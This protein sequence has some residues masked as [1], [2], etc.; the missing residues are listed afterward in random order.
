MK[1]MQLVILLLISSSVFTMDNEVSKVNY[2]LVYSS[3]KES[4]QGRFSEFVAKA[5]NEIS[6]L[7]SDYTSVIENISRMLTEHQISLKI[8]EQNSG[9]LA[10]F[11]HNLDEDTDF[12]GN[13][14]LT[15]DA[16]GKI[17]SEGLSI[18]I[19]CQYARD[20]RSFVVFNKDGTQDLLCETPYCGNEMVNDETG[21]VL[22]EI[23]VTLC[24]FYLILFHEL[25]H[26]KHFLDTV[27]FQSS[28]LEEKA[29]IPYGKA[30][31]V[32]NK[33]SY[34]SK[35]TKEQKAAFGDIAEFEDNIFVEQLYNELESVATEAD[36]TKWK[37]N[38][39][40]KEKALELKGAGLTK[41]NETEEY[42]WS[43]QKIDLSMV[44]QLAARPD[45]E[46]LEEIRTVFG[47]KQD[48]I[49]EDTV[50]ETIGLPPRGV[51]G[52][53]QTKRYV[54][55]SMIQKR[56]AEEKINRDYSIG[57]SSKA[58]DQSEAAYA[59]LL[60]RLLGCSDQT[61]LSGAQIKRGK[62]KNDTL[63]LVRAALNLPLFDP[64]MPVSTPKRHNSKQTEEEEEASS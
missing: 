49:N 27:D 54:L 13:G 20:T 12:D 55:N 44:K 43:G 33:N 42:T 10:C 61:I 17:K 3:D 1:K 64:D 29:F 46:N 41:N 15:P 11:V 40:Q 32:K 37:L 59:P 30:L 34:D 18:D 9:S 16:M 25:L 8:R 26:L 22:R 5:I 52:I 19:N 2:T 50:R 56:Y 7:G 28:N 39:I 47:S 38:I 6:R 36:P 57:M 53:P 48:P 31:L 4:R 60:V 63:K 51:Y 35:L 24:P 14:F 23:G 21:R 45:W 58:M 62:V